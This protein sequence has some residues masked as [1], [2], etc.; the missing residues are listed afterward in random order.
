MSSVSP[1]LSSCFVQWGWSRMSRPG[2]K[3][4]GLALLHDPWQRRICSWF[5]QLQ[6]H[7][8]IWFDHIVWQSVKYCWV[9]WDD[10]CGSYSKNYTFS[11]TGSMISPGRLHLGPGGLKWMKS[12]DFRG[13]FK[14]D[15]AFLFAYSG[16]CHYNLTQTTPNNNKANP[17]NCLQPVMKKQSYSPTAESRVHQ[18]HYQQQQSRRQTCQIISCLHHGT[19]HYWG[20]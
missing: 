9:I 6:N 15:L 8:H 4:P 18:H 5:L 11:Q 12:L 17:Q 13:F 16:L 20:Y 2:T 19:L 3:T 14:Y 10:W 7:F 1:W